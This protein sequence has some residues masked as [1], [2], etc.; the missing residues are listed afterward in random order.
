MRHQLCNNAQKKK[1]NRPLVENTRATND[2]DERD[3][4][5]VKVELVRRKEDE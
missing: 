4:A 2:V 1:D 3:N 5:T